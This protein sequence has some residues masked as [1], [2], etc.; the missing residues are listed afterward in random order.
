MWK[1]ENKRLKGWNAF[2]VSAAVILV[3]FPSGLALAQ[4]LGVSL[5]EAAAKGSANEVRSLLEKGADPEAADKQGRSALMWAAVKGH[6]EVVR[7]LL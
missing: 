1:G 2:V 5:V 4:D 3:V 7:L 6:L